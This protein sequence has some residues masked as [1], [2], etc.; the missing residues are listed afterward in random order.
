[1]FGG[2]QQVWSPHT[3]DNGDFEVSFNSELQ[4]VVQCS[5]SGEYN[6][7]N[8]LAAIAALG[9]FENVKR[10]MEL[11]GTVRDVAVYDDF[12]H[13]PTAIATTVA[14][15]R[16]QIGNARIL[17]VLEPRSNTMKLGAMKDALPGSLAEADLV[18]GYGAKGNGKEELDWNLGEALQPLGEKASAYDDREQLVAVI[19]KDAKPGDQVL[20]MSNGGFGG[21][22][23]KNPERLVW[24][25]MI[26]YL[27]GFRSSPQ[28]FKARL[29]AE[30]MQQLGRADDYLCPQLPASPAAAIDLKKYVG[31]STQYH[32][33]HSFELKREYIAELQIL[34]IDRITQSERYFLIAA[35]GDEVLDWRE[36]VG[37]YPQARQVMIEGS[38]HGISEF[39]DYADAVLAFCGILLS[40]DAAGSGI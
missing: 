5:L 30:R 24:I 28:S 21:R 35:T 26:L 2:E 20:V 10:R 13:H 31:V 37:H 32:S 36:M 19:V 34:Q 8:A 17:V 18:F 23:S 11:R 29:L 7:M 27:H 22:P 39:T 33:E 6:R 40:A 14:G 12:S 3:L 16:K 4:G 15:L 25:E 1:M 9:R 38:D